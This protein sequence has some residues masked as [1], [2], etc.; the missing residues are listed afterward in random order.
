M[1]KIPFLKL[2]NLSE[3]ETNNQ[4]KIIEDFSQIIEEIKIDSYKIE[5]LEKIGQGHQGVVYRARVKGHKEIFAL[6]EVEAYDKEE[7]RHLKSELDILRAC[8]HQN[9]VKFYGLNILPY[10]VQ[11]LMEYMNFGRLSYLVQF[12][13]ALD[14]CIVGVI[15]CQL[16]DAL[17]Y[18]HRE[19]EKI[20]HRD[21]KP[22]NILI[23]ENGVVK[24]SDFGISR[25][26]I[27]TDGKMG[28][29]AGTKLY[30]SPERIRG[31]MAYNSK[32]DIW[33]FGLVLFECALGEFPFKNEIKQN[34]ISEYEYEEFLVTKLRLNFPE[35][36]S[37]DFKDFLSKCLKVNPEERAKAS[38]LIEHIF[39]KKSRKID[40][41]LFKDYLEILK[42]KMQQK[43]KSN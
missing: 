43:P 15:A 42:S 36:F 4:Q 18:M 13:G 17:Q 25:K 40:L 16:L 1:K 2:N 27:G 12:L 30:M 8:N 39:I 26:V 23:N 37:N 29:Y 34:G 3:I 21:L 10:K 6:K 35:T 14:E 22:S 38:D 9:I 7:Q 32:C 5:K 11:I 20:V 19:K 24:I 33:S 41:Q 31:N 28:T